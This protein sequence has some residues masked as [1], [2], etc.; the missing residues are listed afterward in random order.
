MLQKCCSV[1]TSVWSL[2]CE[3]LSCIYFGSLG[4]S[5]F[6]H[7]EETNKFFSIFSTVEDLLS[8]IN[9]SK[10]NHIRFVD[11][12]YMATDLKPLISI[13]TS[14]YQVNTDHRRLV[15]ISSMAG[16]SN[17]STHISEVKVERFNLYSW[18]LDEYKSAIA[19]KDV[20]DN[21]KALACMGLCALVLKALVPPLHAWVWV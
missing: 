11:G 5:S 1:G 14:W 13:C 12:I 8:Q 2:Q 7:F 4:S 10:R 15:F 21:V 17:F 18:T 9:N 20:W 19:E 6:V 16:R 3:N